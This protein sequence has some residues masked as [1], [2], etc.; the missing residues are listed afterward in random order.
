MSL[1]VYAG[2]LRKASQRESDLIKKYDGN[3]NLTPKEVVQANLHS[4]CVCVCCV[5][6]RCTGHLHAGIP[7]LSNG[8]IVLNVWS[9]GKQKKNL[10]QLEQNLYV[11]KK[12]N[13]T[14]R[15]VCD[16]MQQSL[17]VILTFKNVLTIS[18]E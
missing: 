6:L 13:C 4:L 2:L 3:F 9:S 7:M 18:H 16:N 1:D 5:C 8:N 15:L 12:K 17:C 11:K 10:S 14:Q